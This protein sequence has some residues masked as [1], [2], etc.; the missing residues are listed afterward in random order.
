MF[1]VADGILSYILQCTRIMTLI[2]P[3]D[4][5]LQ[6]GMFLWD[7]DSEFT[8]WQH[9][10]MWYVALGLCHWVR[11][12]AALCNVTRSSVIMSLKSLGGSALQLSDVTRGSK[13]MTLNS[14]GGST[15]QCDRRLW[16]DIG[17]LGKLTDPLDQEPHPLLS[18]LQASILAL[19]VPVLLY[20]QFE[21]W[22]RRCFVADQ[23]WLT[24]RIWEEEDWNKVDKPQLATMTHRNNERTHTLT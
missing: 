6:C 17:E 18:A 23:F 4:C 22:W 12:V 9:P 2:S 1:N 19:G 7:H 3:G 5:T 16:D 14:P 21:P 24:T 11:Q 8:K 15:L 13:I 10:A 20:L